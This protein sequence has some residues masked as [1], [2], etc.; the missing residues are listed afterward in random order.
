MKVLI[1]I[2]EIKFVDEIVAQV[3][4]HR[5]KPGTEFIVLTV[6]EPFVPGGYAGVL[7]PSMIAEMSK[8]LWS[9][10]ETLVRAVALRLRDHF[11]S[12]QVRE[13]LLHGTAASTIIETARESGVDLIV[14]GSH[15]RHGFERFVLG[16]VSGKVVSE[17]PSSV[18]VLLPRVVPVKSESPQVYE[19]ARA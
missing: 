15:A 18:M 11:H 8:E 5:W 9:R 14:M 17:A 7:P 12:A 4:A 10:G 13:L 3:C 6:V 1:A 19:S 2:D 16:S